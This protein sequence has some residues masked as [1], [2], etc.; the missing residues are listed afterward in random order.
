MGIFAD[1]TSLK[2]RRLDDESTENGGKMSVPERA[3]VVINILLKLYCGN[4]EEEKCSQI[5]NGQ[6]HIQ[7]YLYFYLQ[8]PHSATLIKLS[9]HFISPSLGIKLRMPHVSFSLWPNILR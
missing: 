2:F 9:L 4:A 7:G 1:F 3:L 6:N 8:P 5:V